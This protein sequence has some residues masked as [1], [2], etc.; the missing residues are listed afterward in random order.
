[1]LLATCQFSFLP[2]HLNPSSR[3]FDIYSGSWISFD[4]SKK[5]GEQ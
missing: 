5:S 4:L 1:M 2:Y 3:S